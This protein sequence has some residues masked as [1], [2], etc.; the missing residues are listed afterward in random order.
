MNTDDLINRL[1]ADVPPVRRGAVGRRIAIGLALGALVSAA[2]VVLR[3]GVRPDL[4]A[5]MH[6][7]PFWMKWAY[8]ISLSIGAL[9]VTAQ[10]A[11]PDTQRPRGLWLIAIPALLL[12]AVA[13]DGADP[14]PADRMAG[15][16]AGT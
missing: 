7:F 15:D 3:M 4:D 8:T 12:A 6:G 9:I 11:R 1:S 13:C 14:H 16:V 5:A 2:F 10:L